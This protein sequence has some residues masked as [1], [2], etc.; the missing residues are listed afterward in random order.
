MLLDRECAGLL[1]NNP[2]GEIVA[3]YGCNVFSVANLDE[4]ME[5]LQSIENK[6][7]AEHV[8]LVDEV[9]GKSWAT[10][11]TTLLTYDRHEGSGAELR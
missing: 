3:E 2:L 4:F 8:R 6:A 1:R 7:P 11:F 10:P 9:Y 5:Y